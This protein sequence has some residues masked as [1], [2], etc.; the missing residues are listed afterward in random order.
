MSLSL[1][2][3]TQTQIEYLSCHIYKG[4]F[5]HK[6]LKKQ[7]AH[8]WKHPLLQQQMSRWHLTLKLWN[9]VF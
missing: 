2:I 7:I 4:T 8:I 3:H 1:C 6:L 9:I 5:R